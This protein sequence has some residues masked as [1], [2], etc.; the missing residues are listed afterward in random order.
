MGGR[1]LYTG[2]LAEGTCCTGVCQCYAITNFSSMSLETLLMR[3]SG[4]KR[5]HMA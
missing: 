4:R 1:K 2:G 3:L 5:S